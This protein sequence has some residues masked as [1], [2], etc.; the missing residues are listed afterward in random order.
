MKKVYFVILLSLFFTDIPA[1]G[2]FERSDS[3]NNKRLI[4]VATGI[5]AFSAGS[6]AALHNV[7]YSDYE[8]SEFHVFNDGQDWL[9]MDKVGHVYTANKLTLKAYELYRWSGL[10]MNKAVFLGSFTSFAYQTTLEIMDGFSADW[11]FSWPDMTSNTIGT[12][13]ASFQQLGF[14]DQLVIFKYSYTPSRYAQYRP[15]VLGATPLE[16]AIKDYN[17]QTYWMSFSPKSF[18]PNSR[19]PQWLCMSFGYSVD[20]KLHGTLDNYT[21]QNGSE[22]VN[23]S[24]Q[25]EFSFSLDIDF[26]KLNIRKPWLQAVVKQFNFLKIPFP[27][28]GIR[29]NQ[30]FAS[31]LYF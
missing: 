20:Q 7:W 6:I 25:R 29:G 28:V 13:S 16:R 23:F 19:V 8:Q 1:Q 10:S 18:F 5:G 31:G 26:S 12:V 4:P 14:H 30:F 24:A 27:A 15:G 11:G 22:T 17:G 21:Y 3:L 9:Q 2:F